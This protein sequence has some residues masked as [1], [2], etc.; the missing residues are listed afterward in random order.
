MI[1]RH[2]VN[3]SIKCTYFRPISTRFNKLSDLFWEQRVGGANPLHP[4]KRIR[5][6][7]ETLVTER[8]GHILAANYDLVVVRSIG[9]VLDEPS[10]G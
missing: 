6:A 7:P 3:G 5:S 1:V 10:G 9:T 2:T 8:T 4:D